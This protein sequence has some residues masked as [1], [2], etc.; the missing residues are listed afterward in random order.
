MCEMC[1]L[2]EVFVFFFFVNVSFIM[3]EFFVK[4]RGKNLKYYRNLEI[5][6]EFGKVFLF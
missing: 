2:D 5:V 3:F 6:G 4:L 1:F